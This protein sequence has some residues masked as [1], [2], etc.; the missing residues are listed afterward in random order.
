ME[1]ADLPGVMAVQSDCYGPAFL[2]PLEVLVQ[3]WHA[4]PETGWVAVSDGAVAA[5]LV[6]YRSELGCLTALGAGFC[7]LPDGDT[8]Y[9]HDLAVSP[10]AAGA[11]LG[12]R[13]V[14]LAL[15]EAW[16]G[17]CGHSALV[18]VQG[19]QAWWQRRGYR[20]VAA[21][22]DPARAALSTYGDG[23]VYMAQALLTPGPMPGAGATISP[24]PR[25]VPPAPRRPGTAPTQAAS[26]PGCGTVPAEAVHR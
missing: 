5:Y 4:S 2:E 21:L 26:V 25:P 6:G 22:D 9:L 17:G 19:S 1:A 14:D 18:S 3:R 10:R 8:L 16:S 15:R 13:L 23:A 12:P 24:L 11:G 20:P 7:P